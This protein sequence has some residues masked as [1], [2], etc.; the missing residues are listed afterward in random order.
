M[1]ALPTEDL[2]SNLGT[3]AVPTILLPAVARGMRTSLPAEPF[4]PAFR[5]QNLQTIYFDSASF[6]LHKARKGGGKYLT[7]RLRCY[8]PAD[9]YAVSAK[10]E[11]QKYRAE[12]DGDL[13]RD[14]IEGLAPGAWMDLL[15]A[16][17]LA[18]L[19]E[20]TGGAVVG[21]VV[22]VYARRYAV[23]DDDDRLT[24]DLGVAT[25]TGKRLGPGV[26]E[27]K[28]TRK[29]RLLPAALAALGLRPVKLSKFLW[30]TDWR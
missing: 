3:W 18:R 20:L 14:L 26:L 28:S 29:G 2:R 23:E 25:D 13:A 24:L 19:L 10:T 4:D 22:T 21:P 11:Q 9:L 8:Q 1:E 7:L 5:G 30:A 27:F 15:P 16:D 6:R 12:I 17:L